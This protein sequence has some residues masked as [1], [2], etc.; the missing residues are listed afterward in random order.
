METKEAMRFILIREHMTQRQLSK[1]L[2]VSDQVV[3][4]RLR[5]ETISTKLVAEMAKGLGYKVVIMKEVIPTPN[6]AFE[7]E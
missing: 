3:S 1:A 7:I 5:Q 4:Q 2:G 6:G